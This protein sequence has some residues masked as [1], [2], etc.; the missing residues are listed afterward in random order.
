MSALAHGVPVRDLA[1]PVQHV[2]GVGPRRAAALA[3]AGVTTVEDLLLHVPKR[4][5]DRRSFTRVADLAPGRRVS[6]AGAIV[7]ASLRRA[8]RFMLFELRL[9]DETGC[10]RALW[11]NQPYLKDALQV[12]RRVVLFGEVERDARGGRLLLMSSPEYELLEESDAPGMHT[13]RIV[14]VYERLGPLGGKSLRRI[15]TGLARSLPGD[16][17]DLL[18]M[19]VRDR[20]GLVSRC[21]A[22][23]SLHDPGEQDLELLGRARSPGHLRLILEEL[24][25]FQLGLAWRRRGLRGQGTGIAFEISDRTREAVKKILPFPLTRAQKRVLKEIADDMR[26]PYPMNR[27][28]QG[29]VGSGKTVVALLAMVVA[30]ESGYQAAF[31]A[32]TE[33]LAEQH[34]AT[35]CRLLAGSGHR[36]QLLTSTLKGADRERALGR[37]ASGEAQIAVGTH[38]LIQERVTFHR[39]GLVVVDEQHR[40]GVL[41]RE[42]LTRKGRRVDALVMTA[43]PIPRTLALTAHGDLDSSVLDAGPPGRRPVRTL[44]KAATQRREVVELVRREAAAG[45]QA[46]VVYPL[47]EESLKLED[48]HAA[49]EMAERWRRALPGVEVGLLHGRMKGPEKEQVMAAFAG[50]EVQV[51]VSTTVIEVGVDVP[52]AS[53]MVIEHA[54]RFGLAQLHQLRGRVGRGEAPSLCVLLTHGRLPAE[55]RE[56]I[57]VLLRSSDGFVIAETDL[58]MRGPGDFFGTRQWGVPKLRVSRLLRDRDL[59][60]RAREEAFRCVDTIGGGD[61]S[62]LETFLV[63]GEWERRFGLGQVG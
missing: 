35:F 21:E 29:D 19:D 32:P 8:R 20:L 41:Q 31:M 12:G 22:F 11:F 17:S 60:E 27:L 3:E 45:R 52:A 63:E 62:P 30:V 47:V 58:E 10:L 38:A 23:R 6:V 40:F 13:G 15:L 53:I 9:D 39:L 28:L 44:H 1:G 56:R 18:P 61:R 34:A 5:E 16:V 36:T 59:L 26:S 42:S 14:P 46:Y 4:Y 57:D 54:E 24:F 48:V 43:T 33:I 37:L 50:G 2:K 49:T 55:A 7:A 51:L 25:L